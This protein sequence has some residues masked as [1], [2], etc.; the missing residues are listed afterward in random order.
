M[1]NTYVENYVQYI[2]SSNVVVDV[3]IK[4]YSKN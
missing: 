1:I 2:R 4:E 3:M